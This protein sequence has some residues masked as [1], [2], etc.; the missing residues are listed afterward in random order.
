LARP[1]PNPAQN[2]TQLYPEEGKMKTNLIASAMLVLGLGLV[3]GTTIVS[4]AP[5]SQC[6]TGASDCVVARVYQYDPDSDAYTWM[7]F[8]NVVAEQTAST[9]NVLVAR[10]SSDNRVPAGAPE[11]TSRVYQYDPDSD[12]FTWLQFPSQ[13]PDK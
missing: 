4:A 6:A 3:G 8:P 12:A 10:A 1:A 9:A 7:Q 11:L 13:A 2:Q 5:P